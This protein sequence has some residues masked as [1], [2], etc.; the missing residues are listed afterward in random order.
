MKFL[1]NLFGSKKR[2][3][4]AVDG[5]INKDFAR[6]AETYR[7]GVTENAEW[8]ESIYEFRELLVSDE[9]AVA[10]VADKKNNTVNV[11]GVVLIDKTVPVEHTDILK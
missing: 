6:L 4:H 1:K 9:S 10:F 3:L 5:T 8:P 2:Y 11:A 7:Y